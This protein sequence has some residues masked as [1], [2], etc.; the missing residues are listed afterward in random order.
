MHAF[1]WRLKSP[2]QVLLPLEQSLFTRKGK[3]KAMTL[4]KTQFIFLS[5][6]QLFFLK[7]EQQFL[8]QVSEG[9]CVL[10][11]KPIF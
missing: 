1:F 9:F 5:K 6:L 4:E 3:T 8:E 2:I 11:T 10:K 7:L